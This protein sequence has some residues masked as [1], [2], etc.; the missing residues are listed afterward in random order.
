MA[1]IASVSMAAIACVSTKHGAHAL[2]CTQLYSIV[3]T[4]PFIFDIVLTQPKW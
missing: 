2:A 4:R 3:I 1:P